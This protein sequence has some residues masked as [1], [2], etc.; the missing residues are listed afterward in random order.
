MVNNDNLAKGLEGERITSDALSR[1]GVSHSSHSLSSIEAYSKTQQ[2][3]GPDLWS[4]EFEMEVK[5]FFTSRLTAQSH[6]DALVKTRW[7]AAVLHLLVQIGG[8]TKKEFYNI[9]NRENVTFIY[10]EEA[11]YLLSK[12]RYYLTKLGIIKE[13]PIPRSTGG[14]RDYIT[15]SGTILSPPSIPPSS[16]PNVPIVA[17]VT[18][19]GLVFCKPPPVIQLNQPS[20]PASQSLN[21]IGAD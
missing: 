20:H 7:L 6:F 19:E 18:T 21:S 10:V 5:H 8:F 16:A 12:L 13:E 11:K 4:N 1:L 14:G 17:P 15:H 2:G 3:V 9:C